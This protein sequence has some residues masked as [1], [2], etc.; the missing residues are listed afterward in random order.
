MKNNNREQIF[1]YIIKEFKL[2]PY[3][4]QIIREMWKSRSYLIPVRHDGWSGTKTLLTI[5]DVL[6]RG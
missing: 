4:E 2:L 5:I 3:Q 6:T 1:D